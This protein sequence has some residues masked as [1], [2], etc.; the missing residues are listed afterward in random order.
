M[1]TLKPNDAPIEVKKNSSVETNNQ[2]DGFNVFTVTPGQIAAQGELIYGGDS[3]EIDLSAGAA[4]PFPYVGKFENA[5]VEVKNSSDNDSANFDAGW[6]T[7]STSPK[8]ALTSTAQKVDQY[9]NIGAQT[10]SGRKTLKLK[11]ASGKAVLA[12]VIIGGNKPIP[13]FLNIQKDEIPESWKKQLGDEVVIKGGP[14]YSKSQNFM[15]QTIFIVNVSLTSDA[16][17]TAALV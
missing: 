12:I 7:L 2:T 1:A 17:F 16:T 13:V 9:G 11:A 15:G 3:K 8:L 10:G 14:D 6:Y 4:V 5:V